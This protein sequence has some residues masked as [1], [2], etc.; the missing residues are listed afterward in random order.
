MRMH[1]LPCGGLPGCG[2]VLSTLPVLAP[3]LMPTAR[4]TLWSSH[5]TDEQLLAHREVKPLPK[6]LQP[7]VAV[8][9]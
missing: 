5:F 1:H 4:A 3:A 2:S 9:I 7:A 8:R 6:A